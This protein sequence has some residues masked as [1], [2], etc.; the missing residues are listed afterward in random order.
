MKETISYK[1]KQLSSKAK[2]SNKKNIKVTLTSGNTTSL[3]EAIKTKEEADVFMKML[4][5]L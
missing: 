2:G 4:R 1:I 3:N 5:S